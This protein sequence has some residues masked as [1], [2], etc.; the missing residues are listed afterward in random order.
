M[1]DYGSELDALETESDELAPES[2][3]FGESDEMG[4]GELWE[5]GEA[6]EGGEAFE[7]A[8][9]FETGAAR[10]FDEVEEMELAG[11]LLEVASEEEL[12]QFLGSLIRRARQAVGRALQSPVGQALGGILKGAA[13]KALPLLGGTL[14]SAIA[15]PTGAATGAQLATSAGRLFGLELEGLSLEDQEYEVA[16][17]FVRF[18]GAA[19]G[20]AT[21]ASPAAPPAEAA[22]AAAVTAAQ[23]HAPGLLRPAG[24]GPGAVGRGAPGARGRWVRRGRRIILLDVYGARAAGQ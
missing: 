22:K 10:V 7:G 18:A 23:A 3:E 17:R 14:G 12:D 11:A 24:G 4:V 8:E 9:I 16:R 20:N 6:S 15:G 21:A 5:S 1:P 13:R 19:A 2:G